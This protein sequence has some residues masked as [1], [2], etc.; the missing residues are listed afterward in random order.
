MRT[1]INI[2]DQLLAEAKKIAAAS[3]TTLSDV[4]ETAMQ[5]MLSKRLQ[6]VAKKPTKLLTYRGRG[7]KQGV[8]LDDTA[9]LHDIMEGA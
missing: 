2:N 3:N 6:K 8:D 5:E 1:T 9:S 4:I 7:L